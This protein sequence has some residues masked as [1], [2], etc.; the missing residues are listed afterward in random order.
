MRGELQPGAFWDSGGFRGRAALE[1]GKGRK[2]DTTSSENPK[3]PEEGM[4]DS[5]SLGREACVSPRQLSR[6]ARRYIYCI[7]ATFLE[8]INVKE[9]IRRNN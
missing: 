8:K 5:R 7:Y 9:I 2:S 6:S 1:Q 3:P 4:A